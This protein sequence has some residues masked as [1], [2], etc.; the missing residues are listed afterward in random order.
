MLQRVNLSNDYYSLC[1]YDVFIGIDEV[2]F[3]VLMGVT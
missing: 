2:Y 1:E 3:G